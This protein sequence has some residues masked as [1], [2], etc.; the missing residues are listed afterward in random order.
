[1]NAATRVHAVAVSVVLAILLVQSGCRTPSLSPIKEVDSTLVRHS[2]SAKEAYAEGDIDAAI[3]EYRKAIRRAWA[4]DNPYESGTA[5]YNLAACMTSLDK[6]AEAKDWLVDARI[7]LCRAGSSTGNTWLLEAKIALQECRFDEAQQMLD[8]AACCTPPCS[9][10][11]HDSCCRPHDPCQ[12]SCV[13]QIPCVGKKLKQK[14]QTE[15]CEDDYQAQIHLARAR[16]A[17]EK[18]DILC[19]EQSF[20]SAC[21]LAADVC[22]EELQAE[23]QN[24]AAMIHLAKGEYFQAACHF[25]KEA[26]HL[27]LAGNFR[28]VPI[29]LE[30]AS[31]AYEQSGRMDLATTRMCRV[32]RIWFGRG[33]T[34]KSWD[35][36]QTASELA[37]FCESQTARIR[38]ALLVNEIERALA[39][40]EVVATR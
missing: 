13:T 1:M 23:L 7:E 9:Q 31:A 38:L 22:S 27:R 15:Q 6:N 19:A 3:R 26:E 40:G 11:G 18:Y 32:A 12:G 25:D 36:V 2:K 16:L 34:K 37:E 35:Y 8:R 10:N 39:D 20:E 14:K 4:I 5:A 24:V 33:E 30:F 21:K 28:E 17:A 29:A